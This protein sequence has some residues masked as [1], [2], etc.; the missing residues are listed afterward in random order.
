[1][2]ADPEQYQRYL[3]FMAEQGAPIEALPVEPVQPE[4]MTLSPDQL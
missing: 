4:G 2:A 1:V 3:N